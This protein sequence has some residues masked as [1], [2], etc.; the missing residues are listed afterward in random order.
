M[1][2]SRIRQLAFTGLAGSLLALAAAAASAQPTA[3][4]PLADELVACR[5]LTVDADRLACLDRVSGA[6]EN[7][8]ESG[9]IAIVERDRAVAAER[10]SFGSATVG[11]TGFLTSLL[12]RV[13]G[14]TS[15]VQAYEDGT[16][17]I[18]SETGDIEA[19]VNVPV[20]EARHAADGKLIIVLEDGQVWR[21]TDAR[22]LYLPRDISGL[23]V[24]IRRGAV[25]SY[26]ISLSNSPISVRARRD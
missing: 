23:T 7:A 16:R 12:G 22:R 20:R 26:F 4:S 15:D 19:L 18:R 3:H 25:G 5:A 2:R 6:I 21:Q 1:A 14:D 17:A 11:A 9:Q 24:D 13:T 8:L 10:S